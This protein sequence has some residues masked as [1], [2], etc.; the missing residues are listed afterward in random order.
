VGD[1]IQ[2]VAEHL[3]D[4]VGGPFKFRFVL[5]PLVVSVLAVIDGLRDARTGHTPFLWT[6]ITRKG[7]RRELVLDAWGSVG[8][9]FVLALTVDVIYQIWVLK[10]VYWGEAVITAV[11]LA[12][13][14]YIV[15]RGLSARLAAR[16]SRRR[17]A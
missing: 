9:A 14:P 4:R 8:K 13:V 5:Q 3:L 17:R 16:L 6:V 1:T 2:R 15:M 7:E 10:T 11:L 12:I